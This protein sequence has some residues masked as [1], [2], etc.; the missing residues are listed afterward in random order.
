M[1]GRAHGRNDPHFE[2]E[3]MF[4]SRGEG[5]KITPP[6][7]LILF[8]L[9]LRVFL[10]FTWLR[11]CCGHWRI[12]YWY[13]YTDACPPIPCPHFFDPCRGSFFSVV[14]LAC[15]EEFITILVGL[16]HIVGQR[17]RSD[18]VRDHHLPS[19]GGR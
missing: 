15:A 1:E 6:L 12:R 7:F 4:Q 14:S 8:F 18:R 10:L 2:G 3:E 11:V 16:P 13:A 19:D 9:F 17:K 5:F